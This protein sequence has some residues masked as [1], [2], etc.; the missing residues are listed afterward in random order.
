[1]QEKYSIGFYKKNVYQIKLFLAHVG[2]E[3]QSQIKLPNDPEYIPK[4][5]TVDDIRKTL[6]H[7]EGH[8]YYSQI[9]TIVLLGATSGMRAEEIYQLQP[10]DIDIDNKLVKIN[11]NPNNGQTTKIQK[12]RVSFFTD[13][14]KQALMEYFDFYEKNNGLKW[15]FNFSHIRRIFKDAPVHVKD[16]RKAFSQTWDKRRGQTSIKKLLMGHSTR[17]D[18]GLMHYNGQN[19]EDLRQ[20]YDVVMG[21]L[22]I[23]E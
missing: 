4:R 8:Q 17:S 19:T 16:L 5:V 15:L 18:V 11:H 6:T 20:I 23:Q 12:S 7:F 9:K 3:W 14:T 2:V 13:E 1:L 10:Q 22:I 21:R